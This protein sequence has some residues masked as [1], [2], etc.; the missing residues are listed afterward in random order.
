MSANTNTLPSRRVS[1][2]SHARRIAGNLHRARSPSTLSHLVPDH[3][4]ELC[5]RLRP[6]TLLV[7]IPL[8]LGSTLAW[9]ANYE[10]VASGHR[11]TPNTLTITIGDSVTFRNAG[12]THNVHAN[13]DSFL[14]AESC[15]GEGGSG[16]PSGANW[17]ST[18]VFNQVGTV[19]Y[20]CDPHAAAGMVGSITVQEAGSEP[21]PSDSVP[22]DSGFSGSWYNADQS[23]HGFNI[24]VL[25]NDGILAYWYVFDDIGTPQ[26]IIAT[27][28]IDGD[29][30]ILDASHALGGFFPP[31]FNPDAITFEPWGQM[32]FTFSDCVTGHVTWTTNVT[33]FSD[34][35]LDITRLTYPAGIVCPAP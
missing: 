21:P 10:V 13:D 30:A 31:N 7:A 19:G 15:R 18:V 9:S 17:E 24:E 25:P 22:I 16:A 23:G 5:K 14:C 26:W 20:R 8:A 33:G 32:T 27:G 28:T 3:L 29:T 34:G 12:G 11:F 1:T 35:E 6:E 2:R 4:T